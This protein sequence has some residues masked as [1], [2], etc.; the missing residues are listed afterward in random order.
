MQASVFPAKSS[1]LVDAQML[2]MLKAFH[3]YI[4]DSV[5]HLVK[6]NLTFEPD[7]AAVNIL[8]V[9]LRKGMPSF[10]YSIL[11]ISTDRGY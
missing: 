5:L 2:E 10:F 9:P 1:L 3:N 4:F 8:I 11:N 6:G 7:K